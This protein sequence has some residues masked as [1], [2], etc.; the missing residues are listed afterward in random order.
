M[1]NQIINNINKTRVWKH[2]RKTCFRF[3]FFF[4]VVVANVLLIAVTLHRQS[5]GWPDSGTY[6][7]THISEHLSWYKSQ[8]Q[9]Q[10]DV[11]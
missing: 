7:T 1:L 4:V 5:R 3:R 11:T 8:V 6:K 2:L 9:L 10:R